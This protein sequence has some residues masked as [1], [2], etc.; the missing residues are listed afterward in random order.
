MLLTDRHHARTMQLWMALAG[1]SLVVSR[2]GRCQ[3]VRDTKG[4][5]TCAFFSPGRL[6]I[7]LHSSIGFAAA[8]G[9]TF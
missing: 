7:T 9:K 5:P 4:L 1:L 8:G 3:T 6:P 2:N